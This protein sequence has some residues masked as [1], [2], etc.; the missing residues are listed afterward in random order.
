MV[1]DKQI[2]I[3]FTIGKYQ[4]DVLCDVIPMESCH[5]LLGRPWQF[6]K[7]AIHDGFV[8]SFSFDHVGRKVT[9]VS[10]SPKEIIEDQKK[11]RE[12][13]QKERKTEKVQ[14]KKSDKKKIETENKV[15]RKNE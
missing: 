2:L 8:N 1:V 15:K 3:S 6:D 5:I 12:K 11:L 14:E 13:I 4:D 10:M 7:H 9:L